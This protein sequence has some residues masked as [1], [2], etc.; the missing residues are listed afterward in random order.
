MFHRGW[1][2]FVNG[3]LVGLSLISIAPASAGHGHLWP[4]SQG[5]PEPAYTHN[6]TD[7]P[8]SKVLIWGPSTTC[9][10]SNFEGRLI[11]AIS[12][13]NAIPGGW[14][15]DS[16]T[17]VALQ[18]AGRFPNGCAAGQ[19][20]DMQFRFI[21]DLTI[22]NSGPGTCLAY[23][24]YLAEADSF[25]QCHLS[26]SSPG[27]GHWNIYLGTV[28]FDTAEWWWSAQSDPPNSPSKAD[29]WSVIDHEMGHLL[30]RRDWWEDHPLCPDVNTPQNLRSTM[31]AYIAY[32]GWGDESLDNAHRNPDNSDDIVST[33]EG[34]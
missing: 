32:S 33:N 3:I 11:D 21:C 34:Y 26:C 5:Y 17:D 4:E 8:D 20:V 1:A 15:W 14:T 23:D 31:C 2:P 25:L 19:Y 9:G 6:H 30:G 24:T 13:P 10:D 16:Y 7:T 29:L 27:V 18:Y 28:A 22:L 12:N